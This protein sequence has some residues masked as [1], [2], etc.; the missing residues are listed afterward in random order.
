M[1]NELRIYGQGKHMES[2]ILNCIIL[3]VLISYLVQ[4]GLAIPLTLPSSGP[5]G[6]R[7]LSPFLIGIHFSSRGVYFSVFIVKIYLIFRSSVYKY[8]NRVLILLL[9]IVVVFA[10]LISFAYVYD[11]VQHSHWSESEGRCVTHYPFWL[12]AAIAFYDL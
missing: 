8:S 3:T 1:G 6:C 4:I 11:H 9:A 10:C 7:I 5:I 2:R 12:F